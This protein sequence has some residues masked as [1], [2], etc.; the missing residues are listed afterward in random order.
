M[1]GKEIRVCTFFKEFKQ[2][3]VTI[4]SHTIYENLL[5]VKVLDSLIDLNGGKNK[6][7][8]EMDNGMKVDFFTNTIIQE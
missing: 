8:L 6:Y 4:A 7:T 3:N 2:N 5:V 1:I